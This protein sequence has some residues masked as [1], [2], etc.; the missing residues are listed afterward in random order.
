MKKLSDYQNE[1]L[2]NLRLLLEFL[3]DVKKVKVTGEMLYRPQELQD[4]YFEQGLSKTRLSN[5]LFKCAIDLNI[6]FKNDIITQIK[7]EDLTKEQSDLLNEIGVFWENLNERNR[8]GGFFKSIYD[9][10]HFEL[11]VI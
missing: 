9:P 2:R 11:N 8:W 1:F 4:I 10:M 3:Q 5:H 7:K 6:F